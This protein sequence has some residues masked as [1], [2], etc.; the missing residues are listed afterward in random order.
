[1]EE[2]Q[3]GGRKVLQQTTV[4]KKWAGVGDYIIGGE[5][6]WTGQA[7]TRPAQYKLRRQ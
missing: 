6:Y 7:T 1:M 2:K 3:F 5:A 4:H